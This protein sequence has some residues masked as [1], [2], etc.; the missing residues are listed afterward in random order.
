MTS[1]PALLNQSV[2]SFRSGSIDH[3]DLARRVNDF[4]RA[5]IA[6]PS[7]ARKATLAQLASSTDEALVAFAK[8][9][10]AALAADDS[11]AVVADGL[12]KKLETSGAKE[13]VLSAQ[14]RSALAKGIVG[15]GK[16]GDAMHALA[17]EIAGELSPRYK[18]SMEPQRKVLIAALPRLA[19]NDLPAAYSLVTINAAAAQRFNGKDRA[20]AVELMK[21]AVEL[22]KKGDGSALVALGKEALKELAVKPKAPKLPNGTL[23]FGNTITL[24]DAAKAQAREEIRAGAKKEVFPSLTG[25]NCGTHGYF[26]TGDAAKKLIELAASDADSIDT[27]GMAVLAL[28]DTADECQIFM[29]L[30]SKD[31]HVANVGRVWF[32]DLEAHDDATTKPKP[33]Y[34]SGFRGAYLLLKDGEYFGLGKNGKPTDAFDLEQFNED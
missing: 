18:A 31:G 15:K 34:P 2:A 22:V 12:V 5:L 30:V 33:E 9:V 3:Y 32:D 19:K 14:Q 26:V 21:S 13:L 23:H 27:E 20:G 4:V 17:Q 10:S 16:D 11:V 7:T 6:E 28:L 29:T 24:S 8:N 25:N 1:A